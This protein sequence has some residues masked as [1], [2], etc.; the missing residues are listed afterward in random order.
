MSRRKKT[1]ISAEINVVPYIDVMLVLLII[2]MITAPMLENGVD[3]DLPSTSSH[4]QVELPEKEAVLLVSI[5]KD[6][7]LYI[8]Y[9][10]KTEHVDHKNLKNKAQAFLKFNKNSKVFIKADKDVRYE[11]ITRAMDLLKGS[12]YQKVGLITQSENK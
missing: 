1:N 11:N 6:E 2:F 3:V 8:S 5:K 4:E 9:L 12:G 7:S 10:G